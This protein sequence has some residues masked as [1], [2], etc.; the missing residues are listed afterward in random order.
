MPRDSGRFV[1]RSPSPEQQEV[2]MLAFLLTGLMAATPNVSWHDDYATAY[3]QAAKEKKDLV[4]HFRDDNR[5]DDAFADPAVV[6][7]LAEGF[8]CLRVP[9]TYQYKGERL[10]DAEFTAEML[11]QPGFV[12]VSMHNEKLPT[13]THTISAH[14][15]VRSRYG[16]APGY[17]AETIKIILD[18]PAHATLSQ[19]S[20]IFAVRVHPERP[21]SVYGAAESA[22][23]D[24]AERHSDRQ[25]RTQN[26]HH[27]DLVATMAG[28]RVNGGH[29]ISDA[30]EV[31]AQSWGTFVGGEN[32][33][34]AAFSCVDAWRHSSGHWS[35]VS[36]GWRYFGYDVAKGANG[37]WYGTGIFG[38]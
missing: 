19:R 34:E 32:V 14:P 29:G 25:A 27:A 11:R 8:V 33:L 10:L 4:I 16:W 30:S 9:T 21:R 1:A 35:A 36:R 6:A 18:L 31:V 13:H 20:M 12:I 23:L 28:L 17:D 37:T 15:L 2:F 26:Q 38:D 22:F 24:H 3:R 5:L 7:R